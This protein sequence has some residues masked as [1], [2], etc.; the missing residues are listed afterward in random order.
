MRP[1]YYAVILVNTLEELEEL[2]QEDLERGMFGYDHNV[3][4]YAGGTFSS[5]KS[6]I[7]MN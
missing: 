1:K 6:V 4:Y 3:G 7:P 5:I 2:E